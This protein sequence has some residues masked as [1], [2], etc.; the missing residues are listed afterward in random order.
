MKRYTLFLSAVLTII[1]ASPLLALAFNGHSSSHNGQ[2]NSYGNDRG[3]SSIR[4][5]PGA[6]DSGG[7]SVSAPP[8]TPPVV[9]GNE[10]TEV[11]YLTSYQAGDNDPAGSTGTYIDGI[12]GNA[13]GIGT[14]ADPIT[15]AVGY[16]GNVADF[17]PGTIFYVPTLEKFFSAGDTCAECHLQVPK[18][19]AV[20]LDMYSGDYSSKTGLAC[21]ENITANYTIEINPP[22]NL[23]VNTTP[24]FNG[25]Q[26]IML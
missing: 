25:T 18:G 4:S 3:H 5:G 7:G 6:S 15:M 9:S 14:Y 2:Q 12:T 24:L 13:G 21:E 20:R 1:A 23:P 22:S 16:V 8:V 17:A 11:A 10:I 19:A 26:C